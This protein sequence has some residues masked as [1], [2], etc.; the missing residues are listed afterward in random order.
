M[1][2]IIPALKLKEGQ[3]GILMVTEKDMDCYIGD[4]VER[5][6]DDLFH[7]G[8]LPFRGFFSPDSGFESDKYCVAVDVSPIPEND[9]V[10]HPSHYTQHPSG[11]EC[12]EITKYMNF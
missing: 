11:I 3:K 4:E 9:A 6:G 8:S 5:K 2:T 7:K 1:K 10:N 12:I